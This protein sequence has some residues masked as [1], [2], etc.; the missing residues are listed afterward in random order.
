MAL[1]HPQIDPVIFALGPIKP[2]WYGL[3]YVL[4]FSLGYLLG[5]YYAKR[6]PALGWDKDQLGDLLFWLM[7]GTIL[8]GRLGYV[9]FYMLVP[10]SIDILIKDPMLPLRIW[11]GGMSFHG[12]LL[13]VTIACIGYAYKY[14]RKILD[15]GD[16]IAPLVTIGLF[17]GRI[18]NF[19]NGELWGRPT[20]VAWGM[21][22]PSAGDHLARHPS[23][24]YQAAWE[25]L[26]LFIVLNLYACRPRYRGQTTGLFLLLYAIGRF[27]SEFVREK[28][29]QM[30]FYLGM[31]M[32]Q[33]LCLPMALIGLYLWLRPQS[34][35]PKP[36]SLSAD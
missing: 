15:I 6:R 25:G 2:T 26:L 12:G 1:Q 13:G 32:G 19:I 7:L 22:F 3:M 17:F 27:L 29:A 10:Y 28:D 21:V 11:D 16:F 18:G 34:A 8:G 33:L 31:T 20:D 35:P 14:E 9:L 4:G 24:L 23:Q 5:V 30:S 36:Y